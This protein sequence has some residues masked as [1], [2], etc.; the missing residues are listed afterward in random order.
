MEDEGVISDFEPSV[1]RTPTQAV[2]RM[3]SILMAV[4]GGVLMVGGVVVLVGNVMGLLP[5]GDLWTTV[6]FGVM[7]LVA[8]ALLALTAALGIAASNNS[9]R[10]GP[11]RFLCYLVCLAVLVAIV[12][13]WGVGSFILFNP[14]VLATTI[15]Y[16]V[17]CSRLAD[18][19]KE[20]HDQGVRGE[21]FLRSR[22][23]RVLHMLSEVIVLNGVGTIVMIVVLA[24]ALLVYGEG[25]SATISGV[26]VTV[27][28][29]LYAVLA[30]GGVA[31][32]VSLVAGSL[33][34]RGSN[35]PE[36]IVP[37]IVVAAVS[38]AV[39]VVR[40]V[41]MILDRSA[42]AVSYDVVFDL[43]FMGY[44]LYLA[45]RIKRQP[46]PEELATVAGDALVSGPAPG[47]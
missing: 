11:Y 21:S 17:I 28:G 43:L 36:K 37:F 9:A 44:C 13:G 7:I 14:I 35:Q 38:C 34:I 4:L 3:V 1:P 15:V 39:D 16:V 18:K 8:G 22:H 30:V 27:S 42:F 33:G 5:G 32:I 26:T 12:W 24:A 46:S 40:A 41:G 29:M 10:V 45:V 47:E 2:L 6:T 23:Q 19:V 31:S 20:E 25:E